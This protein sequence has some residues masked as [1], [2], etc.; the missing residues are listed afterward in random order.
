MDEKRLALEQPSEVNT[1]DA[2]YEQNVQI[3]RAMSPEEYQAFEKKLLWKCDMKIVPW[4]TVSRKS[5]G[6]SPQCADDRPYI[7]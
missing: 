7:V 4:M 1:S 2:E 3:L 6:R 5:S